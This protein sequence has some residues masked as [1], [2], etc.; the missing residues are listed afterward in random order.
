M[1]PCVINYEVITNYRFSIN[2]Q[3]YR[4]GF[5]GVQGYTNRFPTYLKLY[6]V[7]SWLLLIEPSMT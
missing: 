2:W 6:T 7:K 5:L 3:G 4:K 1:A